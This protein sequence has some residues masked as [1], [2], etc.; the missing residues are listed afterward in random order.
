MALADMLIHCGVEVALISDFVG[1]PALRIASEALGLGDV[2]LVEFPLE[3]EDAWVEEFPGQR[4][5]RASDSSGRH[6]TR[7]S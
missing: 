4:I 3:A 7:R 1:M 6:R 5:W 2:A